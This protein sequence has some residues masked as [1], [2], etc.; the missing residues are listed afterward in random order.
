MDTN[1]TDKLDEMEQKLIK[2]MQSQVQNGYYTDAS[3]VSQTLVN[4]ATYRR[5]AAGDKM[6]AR[7]GGTADMP[8]A[9]R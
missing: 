2:K 3:N 4:I 9:A 6:R 1:T 5:L 7:P 8:A